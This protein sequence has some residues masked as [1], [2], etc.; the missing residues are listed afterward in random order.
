[1]SKY[2][3]FFQRINFKTIYFNFTY[4]PFKQAIKFPFLISKNVYLLKTKGQI[5]LEGTIETGMIQIGFG[6]VGIFDKKKSRSIWQVSGK[7]IFKG[8]ARLGHGSK[9]SISENAVLEFGNNF[10]ITAESAIACHNNITFGQD[11][12]VSWECLIMDTDFHKIYNDKKELINPSNPIFIGDKVWIGCRNTI[13]KGTK[14]ANNS[15]IGANSRIASDIS[16]KSGVFVGNPPKLVKEN[17]S[18]EI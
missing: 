15:I 2:L 17:I 13:L 4:L 14:I 3:K 5:V 6:E 12:L 18:W 1:M 7:I 9:I 16:D 10:N 8:T 11:C